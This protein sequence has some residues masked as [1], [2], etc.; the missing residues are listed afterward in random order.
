MGADLFRQL[1]PQ[2]KQMDAWFIEMMDPLN[3]AKDEEEDE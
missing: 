2:H 1:V 3:V